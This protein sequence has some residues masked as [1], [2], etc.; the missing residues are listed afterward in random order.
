MENDPNVDILLATYNGDKYL[1]DLIRS[2][3]EQT[4]SSWRLIV[5]DD[6]SNDGTCQIIQKFTEACPGKIISLNDGK[7]RLGAAG[8]FSVLLENSESN[9]IMLCDQDDVWFKNKI[10]ITLKAMLRL[11]RE[12]WNIPLM[13]FTDLTET[14]EHLNVISTS[15]M[16]SQKLFPSV[17]SD[18]VKLSALNVVAGCTVMIN[19]TALHCVLP[20][21]SGFVM[22]DQ[23][24]A[25]N[26]ARY[27][28]IRFL[29]VS[30]IFYRQHSSN[31][32]GSNK[33]GP[34]YFC[35]KLKTPLIQFRIYRALLTGLSF[36]IS[37]WKFLKYK[38]LFTMKRM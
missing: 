23:W 20:I 7:G 28:R 9:Y 31:V 14:D 2:L 12:H 17:V 30:T 32:L 4:W 21:P 34:G 24:M 10:E 5:R 8:S 15:F 18:P 25:V 3:L 35:R 19:R 22:H 36:R 26:I 38:C 1:D 16:K 13:V 6:G 11:E 29:P 33:V 37:L 27:G